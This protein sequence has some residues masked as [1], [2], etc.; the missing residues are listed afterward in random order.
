LI[1]FGGEDEYPGK[2]AKALEEAKELA[3]LVSSTSLR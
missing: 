2:V 1:E 3:K